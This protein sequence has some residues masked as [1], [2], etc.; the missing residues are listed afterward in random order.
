MAQHDFAA[1]SV[2]MLLFEVK[3]I[4]GLSIVCG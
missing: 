3:V 4:G 2:V 1:W